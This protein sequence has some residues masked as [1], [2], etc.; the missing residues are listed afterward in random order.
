MNIWECK[1]GSS[2]LRPLPMGSDL[3]MRQAVRE[4]Y[5]KLTRENPEFIF[6]GWGATLT[7]SEL[8]VVEHKWTH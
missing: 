6:S 8:I 1:I 7:P 3:P 4:A 2:E 5:L